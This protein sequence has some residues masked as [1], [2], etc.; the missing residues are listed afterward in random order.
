MAA[1]S[2]F[3]TS[4]AC[5]SGIEFGQRSKPFMILEFSV[6]LLVEQLQEKKFLVC[7]NKKNYDFFLLK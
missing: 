5:G 6:A 2:S 4:M 7:K 1:G 3:E